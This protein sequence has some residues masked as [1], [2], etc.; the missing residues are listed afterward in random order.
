MRSY[1]VNSYAKDV[2]L[3]SAS[4]MTQT[5]DQKSYLLIKVQNEDPT[6]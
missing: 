1:L 2:K 3:S 4:Q 6:S 5:A